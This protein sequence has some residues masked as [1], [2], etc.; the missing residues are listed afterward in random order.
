M[1]GNPHIDVWEVAES[2]YPESASSEAKLRFCLR[3]AILAPSNHNAQPW[4]FT[5]NG[6]TVDLYADRSRSLRST[7]PHDRQ[8][9]ISCGCAL[10]HLCV[11]IEHFG[12]E[13][14]VSLFPD[15][16][17]PD[18][19][20]QI[21]IGKQVFPSDAN[22]GLFDAITVRRTNRQL[23]KD[24]ELPE[25][26]E[27]ELREAVES[28]ACS[29]HFSNED[30]ERAK[31]AGLISAG[32]KI[33]WSDKRFRLELAAWTHPSA[34]P[35]SDGIPNY[36]MNLGDILSVAGPMVIR[37]FDLGDGQA[38]KDS[39]IARF[40]P[41]LVVIGSEYDNPRC[42]LATGEA[43]SHLLLL[44]RQHHVSASFL[45]QPV[46]TSSLRPMLAKAIG[47]EDL[48]QIVLRLGFGP[49]VNPTPRRTVDE[50]MF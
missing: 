24:I 46:E 17:D 26:L 48:P 32:D 21:R 30:R 2:D 44:A 28:H 45:N 5:V 9:I 47:R 50:V 3:Y 8:L 42:W 29:A 15:K 1:I 35:S 43:L 33:Q 16:E 19:L 11:T 12:H 38:A 41:S 39:D 22:E 36:A 4:M 31:I 20:A 34:S 14:E 27:T 37:T 7:D 49:H 6:D 25:G 13:P 23:F 40:S 18:L 10:H